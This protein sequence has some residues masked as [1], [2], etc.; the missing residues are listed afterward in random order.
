MVRKESER[1]V[2]VQ[3]RSLVGV[4]LTQKSAP[5][6]FHR[7]GPDPTRNINRGGLGHGEQLSPPRARQPA[8]GADLDL[9]RGGGLH[10]HVANLKG[11]HLAG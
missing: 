2:T 4:N 6:F 7:A 3:P 8:H 11:S 1:F 9:E 5:D 10:M